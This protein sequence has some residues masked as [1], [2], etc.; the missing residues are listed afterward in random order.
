MYFYKLVSE[1]YGQPE[2]EKKA[3]LNYFNNLLK[4]VQI[5]D[6]YRLFSIFLQLLAASSLRSLPLHM[7]EV[8]EEVRATPVAWVASHCVLYSCVICLCGLIIKNLVHFTKV[9]VCR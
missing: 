2:L 3:Y 1:T 9:Q 7:R 6:R 4:T 8:T 5:H